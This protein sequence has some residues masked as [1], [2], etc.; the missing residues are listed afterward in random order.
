MFEVIQGDTGYV[1][2][3]G[4]AKA[5]IMSR[6]NITRSGLRADGTPILRFRAQFAWV[7]DTLMHL[8]MKKRVVL[9]MK[10]K[11]GTESVDILTWDEA[12]FEGG[13]LTLENIM[14]AELK[15]RSRS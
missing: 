1:T 15:E 11:Y 14:Y 5:G 3:A 12:R 13:V 4:A 7:N 10:T 8:K 2:V 9:Q 6:W